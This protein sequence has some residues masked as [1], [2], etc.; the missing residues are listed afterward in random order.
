MKIEIFTVIK[1]E[2]NILPFFINH[3]RTA[4]PDCIIN[5]Y[6]NNSTDNSVEICKLQHCNVFDFPDFIPYVKEEILIDLKNN[7]WKNSSADWIII[8]DV[9]ELLQIN[10]EE[11][12]SLSDDVNVISTKGY[13]MIDITS[14]NLPVDQLTHG[15]YAPPYNKNI[16]FKNKSVQEINYTLGAH[17]CNP[18]P[19]PVFSSKIFKLL[20]Y[21]KYGFTL[22]TFRKRF[23]IINQ[24]KSKNELILFEEVSKKLFEG[25][26]L[27]A[28]KLL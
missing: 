26:Q 24:S 14:D 17:Q 28:I 22:E 16:M 10:S 3:Y 23:E 11:L 5:F 6:D 4:F 20:H 12:K 1:N 18:L 13:N 15:N 9:D 21:N 8:C 25:S 19:N 27:S 7:I 2:E